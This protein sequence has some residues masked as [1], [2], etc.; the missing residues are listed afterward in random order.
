MNGT[1]RRRLVSWLLIG[2]GITL[3]L[4]GPIFLGA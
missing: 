2:L 3:M 1:S 4:L